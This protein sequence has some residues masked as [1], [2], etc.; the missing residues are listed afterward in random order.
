MFKNFNL[1]L[2]FITSICTAQIKVGDDSL[3]HILS[4]LFLLHFL[5][6]IYTRAFIIFL[7]GGIK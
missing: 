5:T 6:N 2:I 3:N 1:S 4:V 7:H